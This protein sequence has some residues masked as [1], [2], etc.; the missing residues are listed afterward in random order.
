[1]GQERRDR[2]RATAG[3]DA[4]RSA[5]PLCSCIRRARVGVSEADYRPANNASRLAS[6][7]HRAAHAVLRTALADTP[8]RSTRST[9]TSSS[10]LVSARPS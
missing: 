2:D 10:P 3:P 5:E 8:R 1:M 7:S 4:M 9:S 6:R